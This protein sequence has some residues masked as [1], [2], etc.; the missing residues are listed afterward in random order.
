[1]NYLGVDPT[2][3]EAR[4]TACVG[5]D[6]SLRL[7]YVG[8]VW[9]DSEI[10]DVVRR[11]NFKLIA[12]DSPLSLPDGLCCLNK[13]CSCQPIS[14]A[15][16]RAC[17][18]ELASRGIPSYFTTKKTFIRPMIERSIRIKK[19][20]EHMGCRVIEVY[21][22]ASK[23]QL[24]GKPIPPKATLRGLK[25]LQDKIVSLIPGLTP[26]E[27]INHD[28]CDAVIAAYTAYLFLQGGTE[29]CGYHAEGLIHI[30]KTRSG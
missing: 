5:L 23:V 27:L 8:M 26:G 25:F 21:P 30:P 19:E 3:N 29:E 17:E 16:G 6:S 28:F 4:P 9:A 1:M 20:L 7:V 18:R 2:L 12:I 22:Y 15:K 14:T 10:L 24:F 13:N 11:F